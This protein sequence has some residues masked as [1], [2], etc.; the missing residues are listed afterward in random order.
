MTKTLE[1][2]TK[3]ARS[4]GG[5]YAADDVIDTMAAFGLEQIAESERRLS[6]AVEAATEM[7]RCIDDERT[8]ST[9]E[10]LHAVNGLAAALAQIRGEAE[11]EEPATE[12]DGCGREWH[13]LNADRLCC[14]CEEKADA[15]VMPYMPAWGGKS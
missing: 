1:Q 12:C 11:A 9:D 6:I 5:T 8:Q 2:I 14:D 15:A 13:N 3:E 7:V 4:F 10:Y